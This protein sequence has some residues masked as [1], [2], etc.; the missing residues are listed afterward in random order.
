M[1]IEKLLSDNN[2]KLSLLAFINFSSKIIFCQAYF[3]FLTAEM[4]ASAP[5][6]CILIYSHY[7]VDST[8]RGWKCIPSLL[9]LFCGKGI[10]S[11][12][13]YDKQFFRVKNSPSPSQISRE[14]DYLRQIQKTHLKRERRGNF[15]MSLYCKN[16]EK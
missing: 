9:F 11:P 4:A 5:S 10:S 3:L 14:F 16:K 8:Q 12:I 15:L 1:R 6:F 13:T 2:I 7:Q